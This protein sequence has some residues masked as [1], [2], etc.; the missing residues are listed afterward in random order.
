MYD[1][2]FDSAEHDD[3]APP[4]G[5]EVVRGAG[6]RGLNRR[7]ILLGGIAGGLAQVSARRLGEAA[8][9]PFPHRGQTRREPLLR[10]GDIWPGR[11][12]PTGYIQPTDSSWMN[13]GGEVASAAV[14]SP[15]PVVAGFDWYTGFDYPI[16]KQGAMWIGLGSN[17][18]TVRA[19]H[20]VVF[21]PPTIPDVIGAWALY[22]QGNTFGCVGFAVSRAAALFNRQLYAGDPLYRAALRI[23]R[24]PGTKD[25]GTDV[26]SGLLVLRDTGAWLVRD[27][28]TSGP[29]RSH[30][31]KSF[32]WLATVTDIQAALGTEESFVRIL[33]SWGTAYPR[34]VR[35][36]MTTLAAIITPMSQIAAPVDRLTGGV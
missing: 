28:K 5:V 17:W 2:T 34:E 18:G 24:I 4:V 14:T 30:G 16:Q 25:L 3:A 19:R 35:M 13:D 1:G 31:I 12:L 6:L 8:N 22:D 23:D 29:L 9:R 10:D 15:G 32:R 36:P 7:S 33:S 20:A 21:R 27:G 11:A 26:D